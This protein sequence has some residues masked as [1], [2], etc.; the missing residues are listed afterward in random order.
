MIDFLMFVKF[1]VTII[2][3]VA[4]T[5]VVAYLISVTIFEEYKK[6]KGAI[7]LLVIIVTLLILMPSPTQVKQFIEEPENCLRGE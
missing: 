7:R 6:I 1:K 4:F 2:L 3:A 5:V